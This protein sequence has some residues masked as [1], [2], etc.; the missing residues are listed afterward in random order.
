MSFTPKEREYINGLVDS[1]LED[2]DVAGFNARAEYMLE[3]IARVYADSAEYADSFTDEELGIIARSIKTYKDRIS[4]IYDSLK[5]ALWKMIGATPG[6]REL[7]SGI[8]VAFRKKSASRRANY[9]KLE[10]EYPE[11]YKSC[12]TVASVDESEPGTMTIKWEK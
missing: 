11:A 5:P 12:V 4:G 8:T 2:G 6:K 9:A 3:R 10:K 7:E 1:W